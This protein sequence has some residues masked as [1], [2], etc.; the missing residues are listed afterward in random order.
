MCM[1]GFSAKPFSVAVRVVTAPVYS[2]EYSSCNCFPSEAQ[3]QDEL[4][5]GGEIFSLCMIVIMAVVYGRGK[6]GTDDDAKPTKYV[7]PER[8]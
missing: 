2:H 7:G 3:A 8:R 1:P 6:E 5:K 4:I